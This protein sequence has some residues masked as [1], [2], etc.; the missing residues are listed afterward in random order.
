MFSS[1]AKWK[2]IKKDRKAYKKYPVEVYYENTRE[3]RLLEAIQ[4]WFDGTW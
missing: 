3:L 1:P 2:Y 4:W